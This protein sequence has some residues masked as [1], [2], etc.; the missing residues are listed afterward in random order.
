MRRIRG[1]LSVAAL[2]GLAWGSVGSAIITWRFWTGFSKFRLPLG[3]LARITGQS[4]VAF[5]V[6]GGVAAIAFS[7]LLAGAERRRTVESLS[8][9]RAAGW[10]ALAAV[11]MMLGIVAFLRP[12]LV[13]LGVLGAVFMGVGAI[14]A[15][16]TISLARRAPV[17]EASEREEPVLA[18]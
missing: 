4:F 2:W 1:A 18:P 7:F 17:I 9:A 8:A 11:T 10:G 13:D 3:L 16:T 14:S 15:G 5:A 6:A 12:P